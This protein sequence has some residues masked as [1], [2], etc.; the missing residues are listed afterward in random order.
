MPTRAALA[1]L[2]AAGACARAQTV[3]Q[4]TYSWAEVVSGTTTPVTAPNSVLEPG[5]GA[6]IRLNMRALVNGASAIG[7]TG[8]R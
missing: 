5:E 7:Q 4:V 3:F 6:I 2:L 8:E 1:L